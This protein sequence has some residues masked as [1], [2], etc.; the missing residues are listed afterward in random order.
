[1][2]EG[3]LSMINPPPPP[4][5][6]KVHRVRRRR[7]GDSPTGSTEGLEGIEGGGFHD[8]R[9]GTGPIGLDPGQVVCI[10]RTSDNTGF[11]MYIIFFYLSI[12]LSVFYF[13]SL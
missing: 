8:V 10:C 9:D 12:L 7:Q 5:I 13:Y 6:V 4:P 11:M 2:I 3:N 1:M